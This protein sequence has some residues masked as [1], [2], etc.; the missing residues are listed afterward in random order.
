VVE[1]ASC[2]ATE[3]ALQAGRVVRI[4]GD[5]LWVARQ[6][7]SGADWAFIPYSA[8]LGAV[9][10]AAMGCVVAASALAARAAA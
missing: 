10:V 1:L 4:V 8:A 5:L 9:E 3:V 2:Q 7:A 6:R